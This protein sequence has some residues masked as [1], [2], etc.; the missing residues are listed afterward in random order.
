MT[1]RVFVDSNVWVYLFSGEDEIKK[2]KAQQFLSNGPIKTLLISYQ[3]MNEV[4]NT[5]KRKRYSE[6]QIR[7][8]IRTLSRICT[9]HDF[10]KKTALLASHIREHHSFSFWDSQLLACAITAQCDLLISEDMQD[11]FALNGTTIKDIFKECE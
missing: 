1:N 11:G 10:T 8:V 7:H 9:V 4:S 6:K 2:R 3:V 5:L